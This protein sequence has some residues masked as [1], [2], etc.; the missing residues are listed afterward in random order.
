MDTFPSSRA[1]STSTDASEVEGATI[2]FD[3][4]LV[5]V[6]CNSPCERLYSFEP[7]QAIG[8]RLDKLFPEALID[9]RQLPSQLVHLSPSIPLEFQFARKRK[10]PLYARI[11]A[12]PVREKLY[13]LE[14]YIPEV[15][16]QPTSSPLPAESL[17]Q[18]F[19]EL[20]LPKFGI[21]QVLILS[22]DATPY[23]NYLF[24]Q[25]HQT[26]TVE[27][28][29]LAY[30]DQ[31]QVALWFDSLPK[32]GFLSYADGDSDPLPVA[33]A[34][35]IQGIV[36][37]PALC[38]Q[39]LPQ[40]D[41][42]LVWGFQST[43]DMWSPNWD[44]DNPF[45]VSL[46]EE[47]LRNQSPHESIKNI[48]DRYQIIAE[49]TSDFIF[50]LE[51]RQDDIVEIKWVSS[52]AR[53]IQQ[54]PQTW[55][56]TLDDLLEYLH[57]EDRIKG[58]QAYEQLKRGE[59]A[60]IL[61]RLMLHQQTPTWM[62]VHAKAILQ[63][64]AHVKMQIFGG[65]SNL[66]PLKSAEK[67][68]A[69][70]EQR[71]R[72]LMEAL[73]LYIRVIDPEGRWLYANQPLR[74]V[75]QIAEGSYI[76]K[77]FLELF[78]PQSKLGPVARKSFELDQHTL[79]SGEA[80]KWDMDLTLPNGEK[81]K[82]SVHRVPL[83]DDISSQPYM[84]IVSRDVTYEREV[85]AELIRSES[86]YKALTE[87]IQDACIA[88]NDQFQVEYWNKAA[89]ALTLIPR[90]KALKASLLDLWPQL[91][92]SQVYQ[93][94]EEVIE[95]H[96]PQ[97]VQDN[98]L[99]D[100]DE[101]VLLHF[102]IY[103]R[104]QGAL[105]LIKDRT[106]V[107]QQEQAIRESE[108]R[109]RLLF[110]FGTDGI[111]LVKNGLFFDCN[112]MAS[113]I[114]GFSKE[115]IIGKTPNILQPEFQY[116]GRPTQEV[117]GEKI[118]HM[119]QFGEVFTEWLYQK[120]DGTTFDAELSLKTISIDGDVFIQ[121]IVRDISE[122]KKAENRLQKLTD[123]LMQT[124]RELQQF[125]YI[126]SHNL[127]APIVNLTSLWEIFTEKSEPEKEEVLIH[128]IGASVHRL[129]ETVN[130][131]I[132]IVAVRDKQ[133]YSLEKLDLSST[134]KGVE[135][136]IQEQIKQA[137][138]EIQLDLSAAPFVYFSPIYLKSI[139]LNLLSNALKYRR[140]G[141]PPLIRVSSEDLEEFICLKVE[142]NGI[143]IDLEK[144]KDRMFRMYQQ[145]QEGIEGKGLG[146]Y[147]VKSQIE[148]LGGKI[149]VQSERGVG[150][151]FLLYF[152]KIQSK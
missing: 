40:T 1:Y 16:P 43:P 34:H 70:Q 113:K 84:V 104:E 67:I 66:T 44:R 85:H 29:H 118:Q 11:T 8:Q 2:V 128:K 141:V 94:L 91:K 127:R 135:V 125:A 148:S 31:W 10:P 69:S 23:K 101:T 87:S 106:E 136:S 64:A 77:T 54:A 115:E 83:K 32:Q 100:Q 149:E 27:E 80:Q 42:V 82:W 24:K 112:L 126:I 46:I 133:S 57:P 105:L 49:I 48:Y 51:V 74:D 147:L 71:F 139:L 109:F 3:D 140:L 95:Q 146:L 123:A 117:M 28:I 114:F 73:P 52:N 58:Y 90:K 62:R 79:A 97:T 103:P 116:D 134:V 26:T 39:R 6:L 75:L 37:C 110:E 61:I 145:L 38:I 150:T 63:P 53:L 111:F 86:R 120:K 130:D 89:E 56:Y 108:E 12:S 47:T 45:L 33:I 59:D 60:E 78:D 102:H 35:E 22:S 98:F 144:N 137:G 65:L 96:A 18:Q 5:A 88:I 30:W 152:R 21:S 72:H 25:Y 99:K 143:G 14:F 122:R 9:W 93:H 19:M 151:K 142:D 132:E 124:N 17:L 4:Q 121:G 92:S 131:L 55:N 15:K 76:G 107:A 50:E 7:S 20:T 13:L 68:I 36:Q 41:G 119:M 81:R 138:A 129:N